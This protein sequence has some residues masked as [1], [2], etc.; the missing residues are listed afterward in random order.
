MVVDCTGHGVPGS[1]LA[2]IARSAF[3]SSNLLESKPG[4]ILT[5]VNKFFLIC[6]KLLKMTIS[7]QK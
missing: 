3:M 2:G 6:S 4:D 7:A 5:E 1:I